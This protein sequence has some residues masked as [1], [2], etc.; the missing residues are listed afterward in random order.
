MD[1]LTCATHKLVM[2]LIK[3]AYVWPYAIIAKKLRASGRYLLR[4]QLHPHILNG[5]GDY[6]SFPSP[7]RPA[8]V[9]LHSLAAACTAFTQSRHSLCIS[10]KCDIVLSVSQSAAMLREI[11]KLSAE[12]S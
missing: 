5:R 3:K 1:G 2:R 7:C 11:T 9:R 8:M 6:S 10:G 12:F 4:L